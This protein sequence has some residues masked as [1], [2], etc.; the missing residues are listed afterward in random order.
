MPD[1]LRRERPSR[2]RV[3]PAR[4]ARRSTSSRASRDT[5]AARRPTTS[6]ATKPGAGVRAGHVGRSAK[7]K[8]D[9]QVSEPPA[10]RSA[11][12]TVRRRRSRLATAVFAVLLIGFVVAFVYPTR[13]YLR[14]RAEL[15]AAETRLAVL[16]RETRT[17]E[18]DSLR[19]ESDAEI[20]RVAREQ[21][22]LIRPGETP[23]VLV[24]ETTPPTTPATDPSSGSGQ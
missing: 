19:L 4:T 12:P 11:S 22:G 3:A 7:P 13:T 18:A 6:R 23:W 24:P 10:R 16:E 8:R 15:S 1:T 2:A 5:A 17:L 14:Q 21:Y 9:R 20:E